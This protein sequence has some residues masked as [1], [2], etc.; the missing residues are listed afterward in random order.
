MTTVQYISIIFAIAIMVVGLYM[1]I[2]GI[3]KQKQTRLGAEQALTR[4]KN[5]IPIV[6][7]KE[8]QIPE[9]QQQSD[10]DHDAEQQELEEANLAF[11]QA[12]SQVIP[13]YD[14]QSAE[15][16]YQHAEQ[17]F[18]HASENQYSGQHSIEQ[19]LT[20]DSQP[21]DEN[22]AAVTA[23]DD[24][25]DDVFSSLASATEKLMPVIETA[26]EPTFE[27]NSPMLDQHL[28]AE[29]DHD[30]NSPLNH[31]QENVNITLI[32]ANEYETIDGKK[33]LALVKQYGLKYG[34]MNMFH[35]YEHKDGSG[36][37]WFSMMG[38]N[39]DG[40]TP[41][42][43]NVLPT[44][45][46]NGLVLFLSLPHPKAV[47]GFDSMMSV[48]NLISNDLNTLILD[49]NNEILTRERRHQLRAQVQQY[50]A[51]NSP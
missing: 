48:V 43:L 36:I 1:I 7:R 46:F 37:L 15:P 32:P 50:Q 9:A 51:A 41:F 42:D 5:G 30:Q 35:R 49:E 38:I 4:D 34:A 14:A 16:E 17:N 44:S 12:N 3:K 2:R 22:T 31:A 13:Q 28:L 39:E 24:C 6:P 27:A 19:L 21:I 45:R 33:I 11:E 40:I 18:D 20:K 8:R 29:A 25:E 47:Q 23:A 10:I 26:E